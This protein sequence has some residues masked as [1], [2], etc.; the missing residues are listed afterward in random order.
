MSVTFD[1]ASVPFG[2][3]FDGGGQPR[4]DRHVWR[5]NC[6]YHVESVHESAW[7]RYFTRPVMMRELT[8]ELLASDWYSH[9]LSF[10]CLFGR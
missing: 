7:Y 8:H 10:A 9:A 6:H 4:R 5:P 2:G 1:D 3:W